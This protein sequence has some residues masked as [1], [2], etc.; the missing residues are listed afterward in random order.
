[1]FTSYEQK[2]PVLSKL[3]WMANC[4]TNA[5]SKMVIVSVFVYKFKDLSNSRGSYHLADIVTSDNSLNQVH[6]IFVRE[7]CCNLD[8]K[9]STYMY[10]YII[11]NKC[12][13]IVSACF[14]AAASGKRMRLLTS[15]YGSCF[16]SASSEGPAHLSSHFQG[17]KSHAVLVANVTQAASWKPHE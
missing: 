3:P 2:H 11:I 14:L 6:S 9:N 5:C 8:S 13:H 12:I 1:M 17:W 16:S 7:T 10:Y 15:L 4:Q